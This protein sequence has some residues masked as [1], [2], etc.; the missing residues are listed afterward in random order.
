MARSR[1]NRSP[2]LLASAALHGAVA[3]LA[4]L[5]WQLGSKKMN[6]G[7]VVSVEIINGPPA[8]PAPAIPAPEPTPATAEE[9]DPTATT[10]PATPAAAQPEPVVQPK[11]VTTPQPP[12][13]KPTAQAPAKPAPQ[14]IGKPAKG[15]NLDQLANSLAHAKPQQ[16]ARRFSLNDLEQSLRKGRGAKGPNKPRAA[17][18]SGEGTTDRASASSVGAL[19]AR[20]GQLWN[21][22]CDVEGAAGINIRVLV[23]VAPGGTVNGAPELVDRSID[24]L[25]A[26]LVSAA[27]HRALAATVRGAPFTELP[28]NFA[29]DIVLNF[30]AKQACSM[31]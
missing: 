21:P 6:L 19:G 7:D 12:P 23:H 18:Q 16:P 20:L 25:G 28:G 13:G 10:P 9:P 17:P 3:V 27:A 4:I 24:P 26:S 1:T 31:R 15:L 2:A 14:G 30:N 5:A 8:E 29:G 22:N 11:Q